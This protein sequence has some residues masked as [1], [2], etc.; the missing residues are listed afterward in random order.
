MQTATAATENLSLITLSIVEISKILAS[1]RGAL[2]VEYG[3]GQEHI[4]GMTEIF[5][6][7]I[8]RE[9]AAEKAL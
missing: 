7:L 6:E 5:L 9:E 4:Q 2:G 8:F 1:R 3:A